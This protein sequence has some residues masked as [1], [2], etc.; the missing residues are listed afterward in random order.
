MSD[1]PHANFI[2]ADDDPG[3]TTM[4][5]RFW[6][7][8][9]HEQLYSTKKSPSVDEKK[10]LEFFEANTKKVGGQY[11]VPIPFKTQTPIFFDNRRQAQARLMRKRKK[12]QGD[13]T[14]FD[15]YNNVIQ[16]NIR[17]GYAEEIPQE[18]IEGENGKVNY[19]CHNSVSHPRKKLRVVFNAAE[20]F[21]GQSF[22][23]Q[24]RACPDLLETIVGILLRFREGQVAVSAD[25]RAFFSRVL[26]PPEQKDYL[27]FI[28]FR[29]GRL[30][31]LVHYRM[32]CQIFGTIAA[33]AA[34]I[35]A[36]NRSVRDAVK[37]SILTAT[38]AERSL[39]DFYSDDY[40]GSFKDTTT[41]VITAL[42]LK[43]AL[44]HGGFEL[45]KFQS[46]DPRV[47]REIVGEAQQENLATVGT[48]GGTALGIGWDLDRDLFFIP[49]RLAELDGPITKRKLLASLMKIYDPMGWLSPFVLP[50]KLIMQQT[51]KGNQTLQW[52]EP[53]PDQI[54]REAQACLNSLH[55][56]SLLEIPRCYARGLSGRIV[57]RQLHTHFLMEAIAPTGPMLI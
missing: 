13:T 40:M 23:D 48:A 52:D 7:L 3:L 49:S 43:E 55:H 50:M 8:E 27:R 33:Q 36:R 32:Q 45:T 16:S 25:I 37:V 4:V 11:Q 21:A 1:L 5:R 12:F 26:I 28:W 15:E 2:M 9:D 57:S 51:C 6:T 54:Q 34:S 31:E 38:E 29:D 30:E 22:N 20:K 10:V 14:Y 47:V 41:A 53:L 35:V 18:Q 39:R 17:E 44:G 56:V 24:V 46:N 42:K 19:I